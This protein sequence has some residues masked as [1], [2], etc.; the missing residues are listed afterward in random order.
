MTASGRSL[1]TIF[2]A[3][4]VVW[5]LV[6][7][8]AL[9]DVNHAALPGVEI[10]SVYIRVEPNGQVGSVHFQLDNHG[11]R[12]LVLEAIRSPL[13]KDGALL[14]RQHGLGQVETEAVIVPKG[15]MLDFATNHFG[16]KLL[17]LTR[18]L[19][20]GE[21]VPLTLGFRGGDIEIEAHVHRHTG[22]SGQDTIHPTRDTDP[23]AM[24]RNHRLVG[25][26]S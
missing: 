15:E 9:G 10:E 14:I 7:L 8:G 3:G 26:G 22:N 24:A 23:S 20:P 21:T 13:A 19:E 5:S 11:T 12:D 6:S 2:V 25:S 18:K 16:A 17:G 1:T 4:L